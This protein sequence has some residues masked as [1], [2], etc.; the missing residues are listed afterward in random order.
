MKF[1]FLISLSCLI[2]SISYTQISITSCND[3]FV[4]HGGS[5]ASYS[6]NELS[7]WLICPDLE[8]EHLELTFTYVD[9]EVA[10]ESENIDSG[11]K[12]LLYIY[13]GID[14]S[15]PLVGRYC[16]QESTDGAESAVAANTLRVGDSFT[17]NGDTGCYFIV[18]ESDNTNSRNGWMADITCCTPTLANHLS[19]GVDC[20]VSINEG[21]TFDFVVDNTCM[22]RG[23][24]TNFTDQDLMGD[25]VPNCV[26]E[27]E[28]MPF[29]VYYTFTANSNGGFTQIDV[30][31]IDDL[32]L[33]YM[34]AL[35]P[36]EDECPMYTGGYVTD[37]MFANDPN[38]IFYNMGPLSTYMVVV[39]SEF[40]GEF[41]L[42]STPATVSLPVE[43]IDYSIDLYN[44]NPQLK[45]STSQEVS[46]AG[47]EILRSYNNR[48]YEV[49]DWVESRSSVNHLTTEYSYE[50]LEDHPYTSVYYYINQ[51][52]YDGRTTAYDVLNISVAQE[53]SY[54]SFPNPTV[55]RFTIDCYS[56]NCDDKVNIKLIDASGRD[57]DCLEVDLPYTRMTSD[58]HSGLYYISIGEGTT[59]H[60]VIQQYVN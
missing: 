47:F 54:N 2:V 42:F 18:F 7:E 28:A 40:E 31:P 1:I 19:D 29:K 16:G 34:Y 53:F 60:R 27:A 30:D 43:M 8:S 6:N 56:R 15:A 10:D 20:P 52:D 41:H 4:D 32:G 50:D 35:G 24:L 59:S 55:D 9:I 44:G 13:D 14:E 17:P 23:G 25:F 21:E 48:D 11:C 3:I 38:S 46:N 33:M 49:I 22:R 26:R 39:T 58:L 5:T 36:L 37:C 51:V 57:V 12:D 45:W